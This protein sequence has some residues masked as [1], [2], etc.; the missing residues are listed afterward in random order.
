MGQHDLLTL[1]LLKR[2]T[3]TRQA[4][5]PRGANHFTYKALWQSAR[6][7]PTVIVIE[8]INLRSSFM[9]HA[10]CTHGD[11]QWSWSFDSNYKVHRYSPH[12][13]LL[14]CGS[15]PTNELSMIHIGP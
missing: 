15:L 11:L 2:F 14:P 9:V 13:A 3:V 6:V 12:Q 1:K 8:L 5:R 10:Y 7:T 4:L